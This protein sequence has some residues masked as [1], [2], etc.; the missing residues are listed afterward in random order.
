M[1]VRTPGAHGT[2]SVLRPCPCRLLP[3]LGQDPCWLGWPQGSCELSR[4]HCPGRQGP[5]APPRPPRVTQGDRSAWRGAGPGAGGPG[6][7]GPGARSELANTGHPDPPQP[8]SVVSSSLC[9]T[10]RCEVSSSPQL[11]TVVISC[12]TQICNTHCPAVSACVHPGKASARARAPFSPRPIHP[13]L[14]GFEY[15][16]QSGQCCGLCVQQA[17]VVNASDSS[18]RIF[19]VSRG[20]RARL[21]GPQGRGGE[22]REGQS[23]HAPRRSPRQA[24]PHP[25]LDRAAVRRTETAGSG[26]PG[27]PGRGGLRKPTGWEAD[28]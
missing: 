25:G 19:Y 3:S 5:G 6:R 7:Q 23:Q 24:G 14:Q 1:E 16:E 8:G 12:E 11:D 10:C 26:A 4:D 9:E 27:P 22:S 20:R 13:S 15:Q 18:T 21:G 2:L 28:T 17:C